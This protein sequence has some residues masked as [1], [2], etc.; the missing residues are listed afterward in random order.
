MSFRKTASD[1]YRD[2]THFDFAGMTNRLLAIAAGIV[3]VSLVILGVRQLNLGI[4]F[5]GGTAWTVT[6]ANKANTADVRKIAEDA[7]LEAPQ[8][9]VLGQDGVRVRSGSVSDETQAI[10]TAGLAEYAGVSAE[11]ISVSDVGPTWGDEVTRQSRNAF[12][13]FLIAV[14][15]YIAFRFEP[16]M[17]VAAFA[18]LGHDLA[19]TIGVYSLF[20]FEV[21]PATI[22]AVLTILGYSLYDTVVVFDK[23]RT[24]EAN[25]GV[26]S[27][28]TYDALVN[29]SVNG[30][31]L[32]SLN[33]S[34]TSLLPVISM[35]VIGSYVLGAVAIRDFGIALFVGMMAGTYSSLMVATPVLDWLKNREP[36]WQEAA[37]RA[38]V[39]GVGTTAAPGKK[40]AG[41]QDPASSAT[42]GTAAT[43]S[44]PARGLTKKQQARQKAQKRK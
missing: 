38:E 16:K 35:L 44:V 1:I 31:L 27:R 13:A 20:Q 8:V 23:I 12:V 33:T 26:N 24:E 15:I 29:S 36:R 9:T 39:A 28:V 42:A 32:R 22:V 19:L 21:S 5:T 14:G 10:V 43:G 3:V 2:D 7:G 34:I 25:A 17:A 30:V 4:D 41:G 37:K 6:G 11:D 18:S 40:P